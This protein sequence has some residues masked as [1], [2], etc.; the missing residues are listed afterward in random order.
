[1]GRRMDK[2]KAIRLWSETEA[3]LD[4]RMAE[5][6]RNPET[7]WIDP[8][9]IVGNVYYVGDRVVACH[10]VDSGDG[11]ILLDTGLPHTTELLFKR[12]VALGFRLEDVRYVV[13]THEHFDHFG[14]SRE[15]QTRFGAKMF[16]HKDGAETF[17]INPHHTEL[18]SSQSPATV[19]V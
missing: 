17:R 1:M 2:E 3:S 19:A 13:H 4:L 14:A 12:I 15:L 18:Q 6:N 16:L 8:F 9:R 11:L 10:L 7:K 5:Y